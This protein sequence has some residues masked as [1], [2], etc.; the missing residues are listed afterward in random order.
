MPSQ[1]L[2]RR[3]SLA[4][5]LSSYPQ[6]LLLSLNETYELL[7]WDALSDTLSI[8][9]GIVLNAIYL[10]ARLDHQGHSSS[11]RDKD[12]FT[13]SRVRDSGVF[14]GK[15]GGIHTLVGPP[16]FPFACD[17]WIRADGS[18]I[19]SLGD[20]WGLVLRTRCIVLLNERIIARSI[21]SQ[22]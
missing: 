3:Q 20:W 21:Q 22:M 16:L 4:Q 11:Y 8:P 18:C 19:C 15:S 5:R 10:L 2:I 13:G 12:I 1:R 14:I 9:I 7:E 6:D 17:S